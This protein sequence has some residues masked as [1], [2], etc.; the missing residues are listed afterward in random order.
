[1]VRAGIWGLYGL[2]VSSASSYL[3]QVLM[4]S[5]LSQQSYSL[6]MV[7]MGSFL[8]FWWLAS[9][10][11]ASVVVGRASIRAMHL[12]LLMVVAFALAAATAFAG[13]AAMGAKPEMVAGAGMSAALSVLVRWSLGVA[14]TEGA[15]GG[16][17][18]ITTSYAVTKA[19][20][21]LVCYDPV[22]AMVI[23]GV[24]ALVG[25]A[26]ALLIPRPR[27]I[28]RLREV[29]ALGLKFAPVPL[30]ANLDLWLAPHWLGV[31]AGQ[32]GV[33]AVLAR[34]FFYLASGLK[35]AML[36]A[37]M[38]NPRAKL[39]LFLAGLPLLAAPVGFVALL[40]VRP[41]LPHPWD[42]FSAELLAWAVAA[43]ASVATLNLAVNG[44]G[45]RSG[46]RWTLALLLAPL[47]LF[48]P[49]LAQ[50]VVALVSTALLAVG[51]SA[52]GTGGPCMRGSVVSCR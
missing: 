14:Q 49:P 48:V 42:A 34:P 27:A 24:A 12:G 52:K 1:M 50:I 37:A 16:F 11:E 3:Y 10:V 6:A 18:L 40:S 5:H 41:V 45:K 8:S 31:S 36:R 4:V 44:L 26:P 33:P 51:S 7:G 39:S 35:P 21:A 19:S 20:L 9:A 47:A 43:Q 46:W 22:F 29:L 23:P 13:M 32:Y 38:E 17:V 30:L 2:L 25:S 28:L 15:W